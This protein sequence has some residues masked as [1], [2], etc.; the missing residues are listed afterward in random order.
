M[1]AGN[2]RNFIIAILL[3]VGVLVGWQYFFAQPQ[4][5]QA[6]QS[7][8]PQAEEVVVDV[9]QPTIDPDVPQP[10]ITDD[11]PQP[12]IAATDAVIYATRDEAIAAGNRVPIQTP[13][14]SGSINL[15]GARIDDLA[16]IN[17]QQC[18]E[19]TLYACPIAEEQGIERDS[20]IILMSPRGAPNSYFADWGW[21]RTEGGANEVVVDVDT[22]W[23]APEGAVLTPQAPLRLEYDAGDGLVFV[24]TISLDEDYMFTVEDQV[25]NTT[26]SDVALTSYGRVTRFG[27]PQSTGFFILHEGMIGFLEG[28]GL[29][30]VDYSALVDDPRVYEPATSGWIGITDKYW[31]TALIPPQGQEFRGEFIRFADDLRYQARFL[32]SM[33]TIVDGGSLTTT[34]NLFAGAK[35]VS[36]VDG[37]DRAMDLPRF[38]LLIDWGWFYFITKP[39]FTLIDW[40]FGLV[41]NFGVAILLATVVIKLVFFPLANRSYRSMA[42]MRK[43][44]PQITALR[45]RHK[46]DRAKQ[47]QAMLEIYKKEKINPVAGCWPI[48]IQIPVFFSLYKVLFVTIEMRH[49]PFFGWI[50]DLSAPDPTSFINLFGLLPFDSPAFIQIGVWPILMGITMWVQMKL[51]PQTPGTPTWIFNILPLVFTF[52]LASFPAGLV[53]YWAWN[54]LLSVTQQMFIMRRHGVPI[55]LVG[56]IRSTFKRKPK[57]GDAGAKS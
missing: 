14:L 17:Y 11:V 40:F 20:P 9:P 48:L 55:D 46:N 26:G 47:Q 25:R 49:A 16:L 44:A 13:S 15:V 53:I 3:S 33:S 2:S 12:A 28:Q 39:M 23:T 43:V 32:G 31:A 38:E 30:E 56:N 4:I 41:G 50:Q 37:Y 1:G 52:M 10:A 24:R 22:V 36:I 29:K 18:V 8:Q 21:I 27:E 5:E 57:K 51:T 6:Q 42:A 34:N 45:E 7:A 35:E 19:S 54:N